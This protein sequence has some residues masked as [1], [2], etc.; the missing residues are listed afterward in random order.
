M[1]QNQNTLQYHTGTLFHVTQKGFTIVELLI[2]VV[3]IAILAAITIVAYNGIQAR[4]NSSA[5]LATANTL[6]RKVNAYYTLSGQYP[7]GV[8][9]FTGLKGASALGAYAE[10]TLPANG[11]NV[12]APSNTNGANTVQV[13]LCTGGVR[14]TPWDF[15]KSGGAGLSA[16][17]ITLGT[18]TTCS[19]ALLAT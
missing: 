3:I 14:I 17:P 13:E 8:T 19:A 10:S 6:A 15:Q 5:A 16:T 9:N 4:A 2:V 1:K 7:T 11:V 12:G 18:T